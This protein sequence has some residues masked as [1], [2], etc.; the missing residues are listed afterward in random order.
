M[1]IQRNEKPLKEVH[2]QERYRSSVGGV[3]EA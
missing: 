1:K 3:N 2:Y